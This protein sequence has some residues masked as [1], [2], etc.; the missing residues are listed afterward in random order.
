MKAIKGPKPWHRAFGRDDDIPTMRKYAEMGEPDALLCL[1]NYIK[2]ETEP[3]LEKIK[4][5]R[6]EKVRRLLR[7][8]IDEAE[9]DRKWLYILNLARSYNENNYDEAPVAL[10]LYEEAANHGSVS[11]MVMAAKMYIKGWGVPTDY[12]KA[13]EWM[14]KAAETGCLA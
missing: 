5:K 1:A 14:K 10:S 12:A 13:A 6:L 11:G 7:L 9:T 2:Y 3:L 8:A 4:T